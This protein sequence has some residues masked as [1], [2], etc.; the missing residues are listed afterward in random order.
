VKDAQHVGSGYRDQMSR[1][2]ATSVRTVGLLL[3]MAVLALQAS[4]R[5]WLTGVDH[6]LTAWLVSHRNPTID[7]LA[8][9]VTNVLGPVET[10]CVAT[11]VAAVIGMT[12]RSILC[13]LTVLVT[14][15]GA[16][17][18]CW[19]IKLLVARPRPPIMI[20]EVLETDYSFLS[21][22]VPGTAALFGILAAAVG[23]GGSRALRVCSSQ[24][25]CSRCRQRRSVGST[26]ACTG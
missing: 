24:S 7:H 22:H 14:V 15:A 11:I 8:V 26:S 17:A 10:A 6:S 12:F 21:G 25:P 5:G 20:Q 9:A 1:W 2:L 13:G 18:L 23:I 3:A 16:S 4:H 19:M